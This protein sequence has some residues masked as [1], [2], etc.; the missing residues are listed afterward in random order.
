MGNQTIPKIDRILG[1]I[2]IHPEYSFHQHRLILDSLLKES[3]VHS[4]NL[5]LSTGQFVSHKDLEAARKKSLTN[6]EDAKKYLVAHGLNLSTLSAL[7][8]VI[9]P[10]SG[11]NKG[12]RKEVKGV[13]HLF[14]G[15]PPLDPNAVPYALKDLV[16]FMD[17]EVNL[18]PITKAIN[19]HISL[20]RVH[21]Y[22]DGNGRAAR[23][24]QNFYLEQRGYPAA[25]ILS[26]DRALNISSLNR[27]LKDRTSGGSTVYEK[28][29]NE[30]VFHD[31]IESKVLASC[32]RLEEELRNRRVYDID[33]YKVRNKEI[34]YTLKKKLASIGKGR[35]M[36]GL[37]VHLVQPNGGKHAKLEVVGD[38]SA[39][40]LRRTV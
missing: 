11:V 22:V 9:E 24:V 20:V 19:A 6:L 18:H 7:G 36:A 12:M 34:A 13:N 1:G 32:E 2:N 33:L 37:A 16:D 25:I 35:G 28:S 23:L 4:A 5:E 15:I 21:P 39:E 17:Q 8:N 30:T 26:S 40:E 38:I 27:A 14:G 29:E 31:F 3:E 10:Q